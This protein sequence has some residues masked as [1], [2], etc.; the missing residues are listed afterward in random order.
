[1]K[2]ETAFHFSLFTVHF[3]LL[4]AWRNVWRNRHRSFITMGSVVGAVVLAVLMAALQKG[5]FENL[6]KNVVS[7]YTGYVQVHAK[8][9]WNE[10]ILENSFE[11]TEELNRAVTDHPGVA[12]V[13]PRLESFA[14]ASG[15]EKTRGCLVVGVDPALEDRITA[16]R[17][18]LVQ[19]E[20]ISRDSSGIL[21]A[22]GLAEKL[23]LRLRDTII[24]L[25]QGYFG[26]TAA[27]KYAIRGLLHFGSPE[28]NNSIVYLPLQEAQIWL[29]ASGRATALALGLE[30]GADPV[31]LTVELRA[32]LPEAYEIMSW[33]D[34]MPEI[35]QHIES[36]TVSLYIFLGVLY[37][38]IAFGIF[39][40]LLMMLVERQREF[41][42]LI[43]L[44]MRKE[45]IAMMTLAES[46]MLTMSGALIGVLVSL[47]VTW[48]FTNYPIR[49]GGAFAKAFEKFGFEAIFPATM[50][51]S[52]FLNQTVLVMI[53]G[54]LLALYPAWRVL[55]IKPV[56][57]MKK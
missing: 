23:G 49:F 48:Y 13:A 25:S 54:V 55:R 34:M 27:G 24:L 41:G 15:G 38:L 10:Q 36:D 1:M 3:S 26:S 35:V 22:G 8:G 52:V 32:E 4:L 39:S 20:F 53:L 7:L 28:L 29:D 50:A 17:S 11:W 51:P 47:P 21:V 46:L 33:K 18:K 45:R 43:A 19:G 5:V 56:E 42:M 2:S 57:A 31:D 40:T 37:L 9:Y 6:I 16:L 44:G 14:L 12:V 30:E